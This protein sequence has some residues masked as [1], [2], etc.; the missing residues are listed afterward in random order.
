MQHLQCFQNLPGDLASPTDSRLVFH[1]SAQIPVLDILHCQ[2][3]ILA[4]LIPAKKL[5]EQMFVLVV[6]VNLVLY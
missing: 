1:I 5:D 6:C 4:V 3:H 2:K